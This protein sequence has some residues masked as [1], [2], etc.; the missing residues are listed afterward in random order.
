MRQTQVRLSLPKT[1]SL[2]ILNQSANKSSKLFRKI[3]R[4]EVGHI[5]FENSVHA[6][7]QEIKE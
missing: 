6:L 7:L 2:T 1:A 5:L 3:K 4:T